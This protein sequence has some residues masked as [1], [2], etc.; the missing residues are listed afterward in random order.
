MPRDYLIELR[1]GTAALWT[2]TN[3]TLL[4]GEE[5]IETDTG[6]RKL[7]DGSTAWNSLAYGKIA[8]TDALDTLTGTV[9]VSNATAPT[10]GYALVANGPTSAMW[11]QQPT[12]PTGQTGSTGPTGGTG[13][14]SNTGPTG[15]QGVTGSTG[16][17][18]ATGPSTG[19]TGATGPTGPTGAS[20]PTGSATGNTGATGTTGPGV[21]YAAD[22][23][24]AFSNWGLT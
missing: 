5:G 9:N 4:A 11:K 10:A 6:L 7:G 21:S 23:L 13:N 3:P 14:T 22:Y 18:G 16:S 20:G 2:S 24:M 12:G 19:N 17:T 8:R 1:R 15:A